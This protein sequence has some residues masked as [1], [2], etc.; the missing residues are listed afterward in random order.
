[1]TLS[2]HHL[3]FERNNAP[4]FSDI[5]CLLSNG[6]MLQ[7]RGANGAGK[8]TLLRII[9][10]YIQPQTGMILWECRNIFQQLDNYTQ[11]ICYLG[12]QNAVK[13]HLTVYENLQLSAA[14]A[15]KKISHEKFIS[16][17]HTMGI[18]HARET[19]AIH[20]SAGQTRRLA[21]SRLLLTSARLWILDEPTTALDAD[22]HDLLMDLLQQH[23]SSGGIAIIAAHHPLEAIHPI[24]MLHL[25]ESVHA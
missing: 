12:H 6:E 4:L 7:I 23:L 3:A 15:N 22:G 17:L 5:N 8:S 25:N 21:L 9:A 1:M 19:Q 11:Q 20:L 18:E 2:I 10:G 14:L 13:P 24:K 16:V